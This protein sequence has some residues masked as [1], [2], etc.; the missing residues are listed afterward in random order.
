MNRNTIDNFSSP[1]DDATTRL[2]REALVAYKEWLKTEDDL[3][4]AMRD[5]FLNVRL[6]DLIDRVEYTDD[7]LEL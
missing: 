2:V 3:E 7:E 5:A 6:D 1:A 4:D